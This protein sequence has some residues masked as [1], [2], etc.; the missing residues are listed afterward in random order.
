MNIGSCE[1]LK[2][3]KRVKPNQIEKNQNGTKKKPEKRTLLFRCFH[4]NE[5]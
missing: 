2:S 5:G 3:A 4:F 1:T